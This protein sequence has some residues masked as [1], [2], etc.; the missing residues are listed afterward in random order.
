MINSRVPEAYYQA[1]RLP[2][3][4]LIKGEPKR[5]L[6]VGCASGQ[7][8][9]YMC[10]RGAQFLVGI[11]Y[12]PEIAALAQAR[13]VA[14]IIVGDVERLDLD[15]EPDS[16]DLVIAGHV[17]EHL[18]DPWTV[19]RTLTGFLRPGGQVVAG[20]PNVRHQS[21]VLP[22]LFFGRWTY[23]PEG[24]MDWTHLRF[25]SRQTIGE[26]MEAAGLT[27]DRIVPEFGRKHRVANAVS[28]H[29]FRHFLAYAYNVSA[30]KPFSN[31]GH[32]RK[33]SR[34]GSRG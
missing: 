9:N 12:S 34:A 10:E 21:V 24:I 30:F 19:L 3:L 1:V 16:F 17:L 5:V 6:E 23:R 25:F 15:L 22:L 11:E 32:D 26:L 18:A 7:T 4:S 14:R 28:F 8:L 29:V 27:V 2:M 20:L 13:G 33:F 31:S